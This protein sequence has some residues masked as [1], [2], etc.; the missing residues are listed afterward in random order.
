MTGELYTSAAGVE[1]AI[2]NA[3]QRAAADDPST[4]RFKAHCDTLI[5]YTHSCRLPK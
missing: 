4:T 1:T 3:A 5:L 2:R